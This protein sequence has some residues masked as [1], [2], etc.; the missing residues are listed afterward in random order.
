MV[1][2]FPPWYLF[3]SNLHFQNKNKYSEMLKKVTQ[4]FKFQ[5]TYIIWLKIFKIKITNKL[6][7]LFALVCNFY[8]FS[9]CS[10]F[11]I[12]NF[13]SLFHIIPRFNF[14]SKKMFM[15]KRKS[16]ILRILT[17]PPSL[18]FFHIFVKSAS[19]LYQKYLTWGYC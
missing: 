19:Q 12:V 3:L 4:R 2:I 5:N 8:I 18:R 10:S 15:K 9:H 1:F 6:S 13:S 17:W 11:F 16:S 7:T 14:N